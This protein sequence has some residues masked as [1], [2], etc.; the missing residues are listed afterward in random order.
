[1]WK[2]DKLHKWLSNSVIESADKR[3]KHRLLKENLSQRSDILDELKELIEQA[4]EDA[5]R[6]FRG[7][8]ANTLDLIG[9]SHIPDLAKKYP[10]CL[11]LT[12]LKGYFGEIFAGLITE[13]LSPFGIDDWIVPAFLFRF[14][15]AAFNELERIKQGGKPR[16]AIP[17]RFGNDCLAFQ[18]GDDGRVR[19]SLICEA[20]CTSGHDTEMIKSAHQQISTP[21]LR[22]ISVWQIIKILEER[23]QD[24]YTFGLISALEA[25][26]LGEV[27]EN[28]ERCDLISYICGQ[29][30]VKTSTWIPTDTSHLEYTGK[31]RLEA[32]ETYLVEVDNFVQKIYS[33][34]EDETEVKELMT[35]ITEPNGR[36]VELARK[37]RQR[38]TEGLPR[39][40]A[41][42]YSQHN[43][44]REGQ[45]GLPSWRL[46]ESLDRL[47]EAVQLLEAA[48]IEREI[49]EDDHW[50]DGVRRAAELLEWLAHPEINL[51][52]LPINLLAAAAYQLAGYPARASGLLGQNPIDDHESEILRAL[53][54]ADFPELLRQLTKYWATPNTIDNSFPDTGLSVNNFHQ[55]VVQET[56]KALGVL[57]AEMRWGEMH[58]LD[59][60]LD[61]LA[62]VSKMLLHGRDFYSWLLATLCSEVIVTYT[63]N[64]MRIQLAEFS[65]VMN[66]FGQKAIDNYLRLGYQRNQTQAWPSQIRGINRLKSQKSFTLCTPTGS[67]K[68]TV[69]ELAILQSLFLA[70]IPDFQEINLD[71]VPFAI[72]LV[73]SRALAAEVEGKLSRVL[74]NL[75]AE[76]V[77]T[78]LYGGTDWGPTDVWLTEKRPTVLICTYEKAEALMRFL[79]PKFRDRISSVVI[80]EA[81]SVQFDG[82]WDDLRRAESRSLRLESL[83]SRLIA[84]L[85]KNDSR[86]VALSAVAVGME[87]ALAGWVSGQDDATPEK[88]PYRSTRQLIGHLLC[89]ANGRFEMRYDLLDG[90]NLR[91]ERGSQDTPYIP[92]P[93]PSCPASPSWEGANKQ[94]RPYL[95]WAAMHL[96]KQDEKG[97]QRAVLISVTQGIEG[98]AKDF[99]TL[100]NITWLNLEK[101]NFFNPPANPDKLEIWQNCLKSCEDYFTAESYEY[102]LLQRGVVV[103]HGKMPG[104]MARLLVEVI[105]ERI[106][107]IVLATST[108]SEGVNLPFETVLIPD[109]RRRGNFYNVREFA[110]L[111]GRAG[112]PG[113][114]TEGRSLV[115]LSARSTQATR[116]FELVNQLQTRGENARSPLAELLTYLEAQW[117]QIL[118]SEQNAH[119]LAWLE[120]TAPL[121]LNDNSADKTDL[122]ETLDSLDAILL[123]AIVE[124]EQIAEDELSLEELE[125][126]LHQIWQRSY[127]R[128]ASQEQE[129][130]GNL[131]VHR[132]LALVEKI[133][134]NST[135]R[136][137]LYRTSLPPR[138]GEELS[139]L[140][141]HLRQH[142]EIGRG[143]AN[144]DDYQRF[145]YIQV[146]VEQLTALPKFRLTQPPTDTTAQNVLRWWFNLFLGTTYPSNEQISEWHSYV[147]QNFGY[148]F[149]WGLGS[150]IALAIDD[151]FGDQLPNVEKWPQTGLPWIVFWLKELIVW[152]TLEPV[153]AYLLARRI[154]VTRS[155]AKELAEKY[156]AEQPNDQ[157]P[158]ELLNAVKIQKWAQ[159]ISS[160][161]EVAQVSRPPIPIQVDL[162]IDSSRIAQ[163]ER[164]VVPVETD[165]K[166][167]WYDPAGYPLAS[168]HKF[169][170]WKSDYL[171]TQ[172]FFLNPSDKTVS[173]RFYI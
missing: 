143:Y 138:S 98:Y 66:P 61:K 11:P 152:G 124:I 36:I 2:S 144:W 9:V 150:L 137:R 23:R 18:L 142:L 108:L 94:L 164:R 99:L 51:N 167:F 101:P 72:Y 105:Q 128:Y 168:C 156:Y 129:R 123:S 46:E 89:L 5:K 7:F 53:L 42:L 119:F 169:E 20:K 135:K 57:C 45:R 100:L 96:A 3:Y 37:V 24:D 120:Q 6:H 153:A 107:H 87:N 110:N 40:H 92:E 76:I 62:S 171:D 56:C 166:L 64:S 151:A 90:A 34:A 131:F 44:L 39:P 73:P 12:T 49:L 139:N 30:P 22:P 70:K 85:D 69:A 158:D 29:P 74:R 54:I 8:L 93:F 14:H 83:G 117:Q 4:H 75:K 16:K 102:R 115:L 43:R 161:R 32:V 148:R 154:A 47:E 162:L 17:G 106:V 81:H 160:R 80:D 132:G 52:Q 48:F 88:T 165:T 55:W 41:R 77:V 163:G 71:V 140:Y 25:L 121:D 86:V 35:K 78:G 134:T 50:R 84:Q 68:T 33:K 60:A 38:S 31:R 116:Y 159:Q 28:Y 10:Q 27:S 19:R 95:F 126:K 97:Q 149:N 63:R 91:F 67:G 21:E 82:K 146:I 125:T 1:M 113:F 173:S 147:N 122:I 112:R 58:R 133:Y 111:V 103:H 172:D 104:L 118:G 79:G 136:R 141:F 157:P 13:N 15:D 145:D 130:L 65:A 114:G 109:L 26:M 155:E 127:A 59:K 170:G